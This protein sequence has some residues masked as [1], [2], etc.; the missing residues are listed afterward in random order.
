MPV[1]LYCSHLVSHRYLTC[2]TYLSF[3][4]WPINSARY[5]Y[6]THIYSCLYL[7]CIRNAFKCGLHDSSR[8]CLMSLKCILLNE[9][10]TGIV[11][12]TSGHFKALQE[13]FY[14]CMTP[15]NKKVSTHQM[16]VLTYWVGTAQTVHTVINVLLT[17]EPSITRI[18][19]A[20]K[21]TYNWKKLW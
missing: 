12:G 10:P 2:E 7:C 6:T 19:K 20:V 5:A 3:L 11:Y 16:E 18:A 14:Q 9:V 17:S 13:T 15:A 8:D 21:S 4:Y 1:I